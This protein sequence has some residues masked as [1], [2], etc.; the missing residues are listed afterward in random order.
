VC[1]LPLDPLVKSMVDAAAA[2][3]L[4]GFEELT[5]QE[6][7]ERP[8]AFP[9]KPEPVGRVE[10]RTLPGPNGPIPV[11]VYTPHG[12]NGPFPCV[13]YFHGGGWVIGSLDSHDD[14]CRM[15]ANRSR[16]VVVSVDYRLAPESKFPVAA[17][18]AYAATTYV[19]QR[20][21]EFGI[22]PARIAVAGDSAG[23]NLAAAVT[24]MTR[25]RQGPSI[26][27]QVLIYPVTDHR[28]DTGSY[29]E[30]AE[31]YFLTRAAMQWFSGH[32]LREASDAENPYA[33][34]L[35][36]KDLKNLPPAHIITAE[37][38]PLRDEGEAYGDRLRAAGVPVVVHRYDGMVHGFVP[39]AQVI[40]QGQQAIDECSEA[41]RRAFG[42]SSTAGEPVGTPTAHQ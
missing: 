12:N 40:P 15:V 21:G 19:A 41:L 33:S 28:F 32:Y 25:D 27:S 42:V 20:P 10:N 4:P 6:A 23:G 29:I 18:D 8:M 3:N 9:P 11:R 26:V 24:L 39:L 5:P 37:F 2:M 35:R 13:V 16:A 38:D 1:E 14:V 7:R 36:A 22:D 31:G 34:P 17:E 30:N